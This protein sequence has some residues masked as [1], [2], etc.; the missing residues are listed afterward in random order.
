MSSMQG[1][2]FPRSVDR[3][4]WMQYLRRE[5]KKHEH[6]ILGSLEQEIQVNKQITNIAKIASLENLYVPMLTN[7]HGNCLFESLKYH[8][9][10]TDYDEFRKDLAYAMY[11]FKDYD[12]FFP[13][14]NVTLTQLFDPTNEIEYVFC[15][16]HSK[17]YKYTFTVMC[18]DLS[19]EFSWTRLPTELI[20]RIMGE[21]FGVQFL[22]YSDSSTFVH[23]IPS[24]AIESTTKIYLGHLG[25]FHYIP[26]AL[27]PKDVDVT[28]L[29]IPA[30]NDA[31]ALFYKWA[32]KMYQEKYSAQNAFDDARRQYIE[33]MN[34]R[35][36]ERLTGQKT[37]N[38]DRKDEKKDE[39]NVENTSEQPTDND[40]CA[41]E[42]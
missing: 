3:R 9:L 21:L 20:L 33:M 39:I 24:E 34:R 15:N 25:E 8:G 4:E 22:I 6:Y 27:A 42:A 18:Q 12:K 17:L 2:D 5:L 1:M 30:Y 31:R 29:P 16:K 28:D 10:I 14:Q 19:S 7:L 32:T 38:D 13:D 37:D 23:K 36:H 41:E 35:Y 26:L 11:I 40:T